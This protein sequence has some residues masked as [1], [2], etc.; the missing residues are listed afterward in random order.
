[1]ESCA[2]GLCWIWAYVRGGG[3]ER[4]RRL[5][6]LSSAS[7]EEGRGLYSFEFFLWTRLQRTAASSLSQP[8]DGTR[9]LVS[10]ESSQNFAF[11]GRC[12]A[13][14]FACFRS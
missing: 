2:A 13:I 3:R 9:Q 14:F 1:M 5:P 11:L 4:R 8:G 7:P 12:L 6:F 10:G